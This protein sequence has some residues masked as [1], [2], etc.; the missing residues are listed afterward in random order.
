MVHSEE[1]KRQTADKV[2]LSSAFSFPDNTCDCWTSSS[3]PNLK[4]STNF[5]PTE[6]VLWRNDI[7]KNRKTWKSKPKSVFISRCNIK[8]TKKKKTLR[9]CFCFHKPPGF[10]PNLFHVYT[11]T[12]QN[13]LFSAQE[14][15]AISAGVPTMVS[16]YSSS[17]SEDT[18]FWCFV[19]RS[20]R[21]ACARQA[22]RIRGGPEN[23]RLPR[24]GQGHLRDGVV[25][26]EKRPFDGRGW[27]AHLELLRRYVAAAVDVVLPPRL[28]GA[29]QSC[30]HT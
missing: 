10:F 29:A 7:L 6:T 27:L 23:I 17:F 4:G 24:V 22:A 1:K 25:S 30:N 11:F 9:N 14:V 3:R 12:T 16:V 2:C 19:N 21:K 20:P 15:P 28:Q 26:C 13:N 18:S 8:Q 5:F